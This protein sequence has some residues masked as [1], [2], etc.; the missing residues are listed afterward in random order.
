VKAPPELALGTRAAAPRPSGARR[1]RGYSRFVQLSKWLLPGIA[2][3][4]LLLVAAWPRLQLA[5]EIV[6]FSLPRID[7]SEA[8]D[9]RMTDARYNG[10]D[11]QNRPFV[12][13]AAV[14]RQTPQTDD[15]VSLEQP[16]ADLTRDN[17]GWV[18]LKAKSGIYQPQSQL[19]DLFG[20][21]V[22]TQDRGD[23]FRSDTAR[24]DMGDGSADGK[25]PVEGDGPFGHVTA[26]GFRI[27]NRGETIIFTGHAHLVLNPHG[28]A[29]PWEP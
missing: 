24:I 12:V 23:E 2:V 29:A 19:L 7:L 22:L 21:V 13:T 10:I 28:G 3:C 15:L 25:D 8:R 20:N 26:Q 27:L 4:L 17:G 1:R 18:R 11:K 5:L 14:A 6:K 9:L 16:Q